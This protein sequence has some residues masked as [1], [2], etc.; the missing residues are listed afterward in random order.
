ME[1]INIGVIGCGDVAVIQ[2]IPIIKNS[3][4]LN[5]AA[6]C[7]KDEKRLEKVA[8]FFGVKNTFNTHEEMLRSGL[9]EAVANLTP[10]AFHYPINLDCIDARVH[11]YCEKPISS[12]IKE[13]DS[14]IE[15]SK[16]NN[17]KFAC[18]PATPINPVVVKS[19]QLLNDGVI[20]KLC[21]AIGFCDHG[22]PASQRY[23]Y[24]Y[25]N[26]V[27]QQQL[28]GFEDL[29]TDPT[30]F[31][32]Q[33]GGALEDIGGYT[34]TTLA[35]LLGSAKNIQCLSGMKIP[36]VEVM[37]GIAC[38]KKI[39]VEIDDCTLMLLAYEEGPF[40]SVSISYGV[41]GTRM[42]DLE[43]YGSEGTISISD[44]YTKL[45]VY[46]EK[47]SGLAAWNK[48]YEDLSGNEPYENLSGWKLGM[49]VEHLADCI[50]ENKEPVINAKLAKHVTE[51]IQ[52]ARQAA[53]SGEKTL[54][55][56]KI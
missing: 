24:Y 34:L 44:D 16:D 39:K 18:A 19:K 20:G 45:E 25:K 40:A 22:G 51:I 36:E 6:L 13:I 27:K 14:L 17:V 29:S 56:S 48:P 4:K 38:G 23:I 55:E 3:E 1:K 35:F 37:G 50:I 9:V 21:Y 33:G 2:Y 30:W 42:P 46:L 5:L 7:D 49:G 43:I 11:T 52:K 47:R 28:Y 32:K 26:L 31:Y 54:I 15:L 10:A 12:K 41:K 53:L 8:K